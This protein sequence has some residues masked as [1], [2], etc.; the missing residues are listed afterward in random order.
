MSPIAIWWFLSGLLGQ[1]AAIPCALAWGWL[2]VRSHRMS[3]GQVPGRARGRFVM[4][5]LLR[6]L[7]TTLC[8]AGFN[9]PSGEHGVALDIG[10]VSSVARHTFEEKL[11]GTEIVLCY[12]SCDAEIGLPVLA[13]WCVF[14]ERALRPVAGCGER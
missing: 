13:E 4:R 1:G 12:D 9:R 8:Y 3:P 6:T 5:V 10:N 11:P 2:Q 7:G 14:E